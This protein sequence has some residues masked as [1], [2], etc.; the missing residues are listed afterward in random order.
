MRRRPL[1]AAAALGLAG[2][3]GAPAHAQARQVALAGRMGRRALL[4]VDGQTVLLA[5]GEARGGVR[6][7]AF[8]G[9]DRARVE[10]GGRTTVLTVGGAPVSI[11]AAGGESGS[12]A[13][14]LAAG[15]GGHFFGRGTI[16]G[17]SVA[18]MVDTGAT[19]VALSQAEA[20]RLRL[21][22]GAGRTVGLSTA[23]GVVAARELTL[24]AVTLGDVTIA[25]V[26][27]VVLPS[28]MPY[29]LLGNS[30]LQRF[31]MRRDNDVMRLELR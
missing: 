26:R 27:A 9:D 17:R 21:D 7:L 8:D 15:P 13:V 28:P 10:W 29:V 3:A 1:L 20:E 4:V 5:P 22:L 6:L 23:N 12:R 24:S 11:G 18:F 25:N 14:V 2:A 31:Q 16:N 19:T 30:F